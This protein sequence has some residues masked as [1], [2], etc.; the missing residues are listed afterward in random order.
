[1]A[2]DRLSKFFNAA[3][4]AP[5]VQRVN[6]GGVLVQHPPGEEAGTEGYSSTVSGGVGGRTYPDDV[7]ISMKEGA[8]FWTGEPFPLIHRVSMYKEHISLMHLYT[9]KCVYVCPLF[10]D[11]EESE[12][13]ENEAIPGEQEGEDE[14][15]LLLLRRRGRT[16][17]S[18][19]LHGCTLQVNKGELVAVV[20]PVGS[21][22]SR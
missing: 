8:F 1:M 13:V 19:A 14:N 18:P 2:I 16:T 7:C 12:P 4:V 6:G 5:Y 21:G 11:P 10:A 20:G 3:E 15:S 17:V 9:C 22:K